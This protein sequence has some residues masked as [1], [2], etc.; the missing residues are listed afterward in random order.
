MVAIK[1]M[2]MPKNC[3]ECKLFHFYIDLNG[4]THFICKCENMEMCGDL[5]NKRHDLC[6]LKEAISKADYKARLKAD[7][8]DMLEEFDLR[9]SEYEDADLIRAEYIR[10][11]I[12][13]KIYDL[14]AESEG[15]K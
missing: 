14:N 9:L 2:E 3:A 8:V 15:T 5:K 4:V 10:Q 7:M 12:Q 6:P 11:D 1:D 13:E